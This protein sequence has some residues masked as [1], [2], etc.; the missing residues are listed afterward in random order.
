MRKGL[1]RLADAARGGEQN[2]GCAEGGIGRTRP[3]VTVDV[4]SPWF[5]PA[6]A[7]VRFLGLIPLVDDPEPAGG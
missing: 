1:S 3:E 7:V 5:E 2:P 4:G 6:P